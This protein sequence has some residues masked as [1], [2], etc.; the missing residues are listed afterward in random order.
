MARPLGSLKCPAPLVLI[1]AAAELAAVVV[2]L[3]LMA[4]MLVRLAVA[5]LLQQ[6]LQVRLGGCGP[7]LAC[8]AAVQVLLCG[9]LAPAAVVHPSR[10]S[11]S[12]SRRLMHQCWDAGV[13]RAMQEHGWEA[14]QALVLGPLTQQQLVSG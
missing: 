8:P 6:G 11:G 3:L 1:E 10:H 4:L 12:S 2:G 9:A 7:W 14:L 13:H 5:Q